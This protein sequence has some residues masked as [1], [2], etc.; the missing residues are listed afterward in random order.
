MLASH[1]SKKCK[2][3]IKRQGWDVQEALINWDDTFD[4]LI[5]WGESNE[6]RICSLKDTKETLRKL[7]QNPSGYVDELLMSLLNIKIRKLKYKLK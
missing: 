6:K 5:K 3:E 2:E 1:I 4:H 7:L